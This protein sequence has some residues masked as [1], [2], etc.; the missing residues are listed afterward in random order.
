M[1]KYQENYQGYWEDE[2][3]EFVSLHNNSIKGYFE[4]ENGTKVC[5]TEFYIDSQGKLRFVA[6]K[7]E[8]TSPS[9]ALQE[10]GGGKDSL[11]ARRKVLGGTTFHIYR[12]L[13]FIINE[14]KAS[15]EEILN[16]MG[17]DLS[18]NLKGKPTGTGRW[19]NWN[20]LPA[21]KSIFDLYGNKIGTVLVSKGYK[22]D[23]IVRDLDGMKLSDFKVKYK[24][25]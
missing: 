23:D 25:G 15:M 6:D 20:D 1:S 8:Y 14:Q 19:Y 9:A 11:V 21:R 7:D 22:K 17:I 12:K 2:I 16:D 13:V 18:R 10:M 4:H 5:D 24:L 3:K